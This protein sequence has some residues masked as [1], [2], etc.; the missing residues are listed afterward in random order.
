MKKEGI[1][2]VGFDM[3]IADLDKKGLLREAHRV[4]WMTWA[5][6]SNDHSLCIT[7][8]VPETHCLS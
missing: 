5:F 2:L 7:H 1:T 4:G 6:S 8:H 3:V